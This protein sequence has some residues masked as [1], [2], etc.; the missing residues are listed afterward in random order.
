MKKI[1]KQLKPVAGIAV[2]ILILTAVCFALIQAG[3]NVPERYDFKKSSVKVMGKY[4]HGSAAIID[5]TEDSSLVLTNKH[6]CEGITVNPALKEALKTLFKI[7]MYFPKCKTFPCVYK[8]NPMVG[9]V[10]LNLFYRLGDSISLKTDKIADMVVLVKEAIKRDK[11]NNKI[12]IKFN[13]LLI[14]P[15][16]AKIHA[17]S[18]NFDLCLIKIPVGNLQPVKIANKIPKVGDKV[19][20]I[21]NP[22]SAENHYVEGFVG[23]NEYI[24]GNNYTLISA[25]IYGGQSGS[26]T[27]NMLEELVCV[28][29]LT[30]P[31]AATIGYCIPLGDIKLFLQGKM[32]NRKIK[33]EI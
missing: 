1:L 26:G 19:Q 28:N 27:F 2:K 30:D 16:E 8:K 6:V 18:K 33:M 12:L 7:K 22:H 3:K 21:G 31:S 15:A 32:I 11:K 14:E 23:N 25:P 20:T 10:M 29:T 17:V 24:Y 9:L 13:N 4:G 5:T